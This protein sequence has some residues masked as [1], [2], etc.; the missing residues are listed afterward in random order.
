MLLQDIGSKD[1]D[2]EL[3]LIA[4]VYKISMITCTLL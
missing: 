1:M 3:C 2:S 4:R